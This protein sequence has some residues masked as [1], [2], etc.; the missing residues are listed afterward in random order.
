MRSEK[1]LRLAE[2]CRHAFGVVGS[3]GGTFPH[4]AVGET[5]NPTLFSRNCWKLNVGNFSNNIQIILK[6]G[7]IF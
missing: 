2:K 6:D 4:L 7:I 1:H 3:A 5:H